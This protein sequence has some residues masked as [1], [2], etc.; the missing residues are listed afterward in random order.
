MVS[1]LLCADDCFLFF[2][3]NVVEAQRLLSILKTYE[4]SSGQE[5]NLSKPDVFFSCN[6][7]GATQEDL[8]RIIGVRHV[9]DTGKYLELPSV[10]D[11]DTRYVF[12]IIK[13]CIWRR[14][15]A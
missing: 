11:R 6:M 14:I 7:S 4:A 3:A 13:D 8:S 5:I 1:H 15:N 10:I 12:S 9:M 2:R